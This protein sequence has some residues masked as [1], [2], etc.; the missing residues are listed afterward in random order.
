MPQL[1][2]H[3]IPLDPQ[4]AAALL[5]PAVMMKAGTL[6]LSGSNCRV[7]DRMSDY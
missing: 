3:L 1:Q 7:S 2:G 6:Y 4:D 5:A